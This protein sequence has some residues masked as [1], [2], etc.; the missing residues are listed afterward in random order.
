MRRILKPKQPPKAAQAL[1]PA[2]AGSQRV[3]AIGDIHGRLDL[4]NALLGMIEKDMGEKATQSKIVFLGDYID[5][6]PDSKGVIERLMAPLPGDGSPVFLLGN[7]EQVLLGLFN[8]L[9]G[10]PG[11]LSYGGLATL[12]SY[13]IPCP[14]GTPTEERLKELQNNLKEKFPPAHKDFL[15]KMPLFW[16]C[17]DYYF[18]HAGVHPEKP[19]AVQT[20][21]DQLW[22]RHGFLDWTGGPLEKMIV[23]GH[24][25]SAKPQRRLHR[26]GIDTGAYA[27]GNLT[28]LVLEGTTRRLLQTGS[29]KDLTG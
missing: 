24:T 17:G 14:M 23:H 8:K 10:G 29:A 19:L 9:E 2:I 7:H 11:W 28:A 25:V 22:I 13:G 3:Y 5:R 15:A 1:P 4:L 27:S 16:I 18:V 12:L 6:G 21:R 26:I 20:E